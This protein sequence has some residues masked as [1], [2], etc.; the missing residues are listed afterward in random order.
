[1]STQGGWVYPALGEYLQVY[2]RG[3][4]PGVSAQGVSNWGEH[5]GRVSSQEVS[6]PGVGTESLLL[7]HSG[8]H[9]NMYSCQASST[10]PTVMLSC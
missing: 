7:T 8:G 9:Q 1:M 4:Y 3:E 5:S 10:Y 6:I 2:P